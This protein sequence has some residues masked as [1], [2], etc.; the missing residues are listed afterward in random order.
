[1]SNKIYLGRE[2]GLGLGVRSDFVG[3]VKLVVGGKVW[4][5]RFAGVD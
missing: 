5:V 2:T 1:V 4:G 3:R